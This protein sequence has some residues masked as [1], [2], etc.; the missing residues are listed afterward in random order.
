MVSFPTERGSE[1][2]NL[3]AGLE[4][5]TSADLVICQELGVVFEHKAARVFSRHLVVDLVEGVLVNVLSG[6]FRDIFVGHQRLVVCN[7]ILL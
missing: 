5:A 6:L 1:V 7:G 4:N 3:A 2:V